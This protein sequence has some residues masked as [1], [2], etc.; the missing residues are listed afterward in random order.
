MKFVVKNFDLFQTN[1]F[2]DDFDTEA[3]C[4]PFIFSEGS[5][6]FGDANL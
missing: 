1:T 2:I 6:L 5:L 4:Q 3:C